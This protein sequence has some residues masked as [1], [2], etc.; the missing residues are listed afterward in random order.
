MIR[1]NDQQFWRYA[2]ADP[3]TNDLLHLRLFST[4]TIALTEIFPENS[5]RNTTSNPTY[6]WS[7]ALNTSNLRWPEQHFN[8][9]L[10]TIVQSE[11]SRLNFELSISIWGE[12]IAYIELLF[13]EPLFIRIP[14]HCFQSV[15][16]RF[17]AIGPIVITHYFPRPLH[18]A[19]KPW[20]RILQRSRVSDSLEAQFLCF[21]ERFIEFLC[22]P[23]VLFINIRAQDDC[24]HN[25]EMPCLLVI[26]SLDVPEIGKQANDR[27]SI[28]RRRRSG[29]D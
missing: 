11:D 5:D 12:E 6:F 7:I 21:V 4:A 18:F 10:N 3:D 25:G 14:S 24:M 27:F 1:T 9:K 13:C 15:P 8:F 28:E 16:V 19:M 29:C 22:Y 17:D 2:A 23:R 26:F 20:Q